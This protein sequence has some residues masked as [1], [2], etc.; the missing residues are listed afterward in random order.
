M[1]LDFGGDGEWKE[2]IK[3]EIRKSFKKMLNE[4][5]LKLAHS[6]GKLKVKHDSIFIESCFFVG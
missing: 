4:K 3:L 6:I 1:C 2:G 5:S